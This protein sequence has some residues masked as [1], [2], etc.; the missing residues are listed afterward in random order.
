[1]L[2]RNVGIFTPPSVLLI[3]SVFFAF[4][5]PRADERPVEDARKA[6]LQSKPRSDLP[7]VWII[8]DSTVRVGTRDQRGWGDELAT[9]FDHTKVNLVN[10]AIGGRSSRTFLTE[11]RWDDILRELRAGDLV[12]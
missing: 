8:G 2:P 5:S 12:L 11:G 10:R 3:A 7:T 1:M 6:G 9:F 4:A